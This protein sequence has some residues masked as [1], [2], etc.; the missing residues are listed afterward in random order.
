MKFEC[1]IDGTEEK[2]EAKRPACFKC[3]TGKKHS[4][5]VTNKASTKPK[6]S[7]TSNDCKFTNAIGVGVTSYPNFRYY[8]I[9]ECWQLKTCTR[10]GF[11]FVKKFI[12][13]VGSADTVLTRPNLR[14]LKQISGDGNCL[15]RAIQF[16]I[17][18]SEEQH[19]ILRSVVISY[20]M[21][22][23]HLLVGCRS[24]GHWNYVDALTTTDH[25]STE[26]YI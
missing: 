18:G 3:I 25:S 19:F 23:S 9:D 11:Q 22:M 26:Q 1:I 16:I 4:K 17:T 24:D 20:M 2:S 5:S 6:K 14:G 12:C 15:F 13:S 8:Q 7:K 21:S 10:L